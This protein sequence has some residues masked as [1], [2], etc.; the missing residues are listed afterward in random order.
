MSGNDQTIDHP[1]RRRLPGPDE[2]NSALD[3]SIAEAEQRGDFANLPGHGKPI[4]FQANP[5]TGEIDVG[6]GLLK[7]AGY[8]PAWIELDKEIR[9]KLDA[10][11]AT[12]AHA[13][14]YLAQLS[15]SPATT[16]A[17]PPATRRRSWWQT[18]LHGSR[19]NRATP[20]PKPRPIDR[21]TAHAQALE[22][23][24]AQA[25]ELDQKITDFNSSIPRELWHLE[26]PRLTPDI[27]R[28]DFEAAVAQEMSPNQEGEIE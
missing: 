16:E 6:L 11:A 1:L 27:A 15:E 19:A 24:L 18:V 20:A 9:A 13:A 17:E 28:R 5:L 2:W 3:R 22:N 8:A 4:D 21:T 7:S 12:R 26:R 25:K 14:R 10:L 23:Y